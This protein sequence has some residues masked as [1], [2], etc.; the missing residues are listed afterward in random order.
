MNWM[1]KG[2]YEYWLTPEGLLK[3]EGWARDGL[4]DEQIAHNMGISRSTL[5]KWKN[6]AFGHFGHLK[7]RERDC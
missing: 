2:K 6:E 3:L 5:N 4:T 1:A 7:K